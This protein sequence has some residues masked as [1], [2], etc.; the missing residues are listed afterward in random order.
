MVLNDPP[1]YKSKM[2]DQRIYVGANLKYALPQA[3][4]REKLKT[5]ATATWKGN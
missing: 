2:M 3:E 1:K 5:N 4:D